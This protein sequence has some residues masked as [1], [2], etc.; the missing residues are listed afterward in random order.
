MGLGSLPGD[1]FGM[2]QVDLAG[3]QRIERVSQGV[4]CERFGESGFAAGLRAVHPRVLAQLPRS[5]LRSVSG[6]QL[7]DRR[8]ILRLDAGPLRRQLDDTV[9][10]IAVGQR[11]Q[12]QPRRTLRLNE[13]AALGAP[14]TGPDL[15]SLTVEFGPVRLVTSRLCGIVRSTDRMHFRHGNTAAGTVL[16]AQLGEHETS[17]HTNVRTNKHSRASESPRFDVGNRVGVPLSSC[18]PIESGNNPPA[19]LVTNGTCTTTRPVA[20]PLATGAK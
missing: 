16:E 7:A 15:G 2:G 13:R 20:W 3:R 12:P 6:H 9:Q 10:Q 1:H 18:G 8:Q 5:R 17:I 11:L 14:S 19:H 4:L